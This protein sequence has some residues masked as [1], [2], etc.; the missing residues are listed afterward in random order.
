MSDWEKPKN[1]DEIAIGGLVEVGGNA[2]D[3]KTGGWRTYRPI[4][5]KD[6]CTQCL[7]C[8]IYCPDSSWIIKDKA[9]VGVNLDHCKGCGICAVEC[10]PKIQAITMVLENEVE[11]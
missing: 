10:P 3:Y 2:H 8:W 9:I 1:W 4:W 11:E 7:L 5:D 6:K